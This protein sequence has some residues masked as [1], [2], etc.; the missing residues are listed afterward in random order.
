MEDLQQD[1]QRPLLL[2]RN[3]FFS[4]VGG[5]EILTVAKFLLTQELV[6]SDAEFCPL[7]QP[8]LLLLVPTVIV[9]ELDHLQTLGVQP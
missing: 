4:I 1:G 6:L 2:Q 7:R 5:E 3:A 9:I 8:S